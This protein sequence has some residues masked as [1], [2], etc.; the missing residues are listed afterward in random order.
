M[1]EV[2]QLIL[3]DWSRKKTAPRHMAWLHEA[4]VATR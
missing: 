1:N 3:E 4:E 2:A